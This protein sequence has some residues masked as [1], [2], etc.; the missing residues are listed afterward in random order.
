MEEKAERRKKRVGIMGGTFDPIHVGHLILGEAAYL[1]FGLDEVHF[2]PAGNPPH[3]QNRAGRASDEQRVEM[4]RRAI[5]SNPHFH[6]SL[7]EMNADGYTYTYRTLERLKAENPDNEYY[8]VM[9]ADSLVDFDTW[10][11]PQ[12]IVDAAHLVV[13]TRNQTDPKV[14]ESL[15]AKRRAQFNGDFLKMDTPNLDISSNNLRKKIR[16][17]ESAKYYILDTVLEY[18]EENNIYKQEETEEQ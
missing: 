14:F 2:M 13:A 4:V 12:R 16:S 18:I 17:G 15:L 8:F 3:K 10:R 9:G 5:A 11:E 1:Q 7:V 6:L